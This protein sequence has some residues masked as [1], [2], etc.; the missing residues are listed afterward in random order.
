M[1]PT[2]YKKV[3]FAVKTDIAKNSPVVKNIKNQ[4]ISGNKDLEKLNKFFSTNSSKVEIEARMGSF[5]GNYFQSGVPFQVFNRIKTVLLGMSTK[6]GGNFEILN[7][8][9]KVYSTEDYLKIINLNTNQPP[10]Y[11]SKQKTGKIDVY[12]WNY[13]ISQAVE[14]NLN[15]A[16][17][18]EKFNDTAFRIKER[19]SFTDRQDGYFFGVSIDMTKVETSKEVDIKGKNG[20]TTKQIKSFTSYE[21]EMERNSNLTLEDFM[22]KFEFLYFI[23]QGY[24]KLFLDNIS[25]YYNIFN[26]NKN[27]LM[28][29][30]VKKQIIYE[31]NQL[32]I[33]QDLNDTFIPQIKQKDD[34]KLI[35][36]RNEPKNIKIKDMLSLEKY[37]TTSKLD[38]IRTFAFFQKN[39]VYFVNPPYDIIRITKYTNLTYQD[40]IIDGEF[41]TN[42]EDK[43]N[44]FYM[45]DI[46]RLY[47]KSVENKQ[48]HTRYELLK[49]ASEETQLFINPINFQL[50]TFYF[51]SNFYENIRDTLLDNNLFEL[52]EI[53]TDG[54]IIQPINKPYLNRQTFKWKPIEQLT[55]DF[56]VVSVI[57]E[58]EEY[59]LTTFDKFSNKLTSFRGTSDNPFFKTTFISDGIFE[60]EKINNRIVEFK[61]DYDHEVFVPM[62]YRDDRPIPNRSDVATSVWNDIMNPIYKST[63]EG[64]DLVVMR[65]YHNLIKQHL[66]TQYV[67]Q[68]STMLDIG[69]GRG[70]DLLKWKKLN[71]K[72][73]VVEPNEEVIVEFKRRQENLKTDAKIIMA[74]AQDTKIIT[75]QLKGEKVDVI[76]AFFSLTFFP[77]N[78]EMFQGLIDTIDQTLKNEG[79]LIGIVLDGH[80]VMKLL[81]TLKTYENDAFSIRKANTWK[82]SAFGNKLLVNIN[83]PS[84]M[85]KEVHEYLFFFDE[86]KNRLRNIGINLYLQPTIEGNNDK[87]SLKSK[88]DESFIDK[89]TEFLPHDAQIFSGLNRCFVFQR[90]KLKLSPPLTKLLKGDEPIDLKFGYDLYQEASINDNSSLF[91]AIVQTFSEDYRHKTINEKKL[92]IEKIRKK[93]AFNMSTHDFDS[94]GGGILANKLTKSYKIY[95]KNEKTA[96]TLS[97][98][99]MIN[100]LNNPNEWIGDNLEIVQLLSDKLGLD[101]YLV[102]NKS[103]NVYL[104]DAENLISKNYKCKLLYKNRPSVIILNIDNLRFNVIKQNNKYLFPPQSSI[105]KGIRKQLCTATNITDQ[106]QDEI[107]V[108]Y[109][110]YNKWTKAIVNNSDVL[111]LEPLYKNQKKI[112]VM[113]IDPSAPP[114]FRRVNVS[115]LIIKTKSQ[116][117]FETFKK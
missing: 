3:S 44:V 28:P 43:R 32:L 100:L 9:T 94:L 46:L 75:K 57:D 38:G 107:P 13:R 60:N 105:I 36:Y 117:E 47:S 82:K 8:N 99:K 68:G 18:G 80:K 30:D 23:Y 1:K 16:P 51:H 53:K 71:L 79:M 15:K 92:F 87:L 39:A 78:E 106:S 29:V 113:P 20:K 85:V 97:I 48:F 26:K 111:L 114:Q 62:R 86:F 17:E 27:L 96:H 35:S 112:E 101:I 93:I 50:K 102:D 74:G 110:E 19:T 41:V 88:Y 12:K 24:N 61:W 6:K 98:N 109:L 81:S 49:K 84:S 2:K 63:I 55:I 7:T 104:P 77:K 14:Q 73:T 11:R 72:V 56:Q 90:T 5:D 83:D 103:K 10:F 22:N 95:T 33:N 116:S 69:S 37:A 21:I 89:N 76:A 45:F 42:I 34:E 108:E 67:A 52:N 40:T 4:L 65:K 58:E 115:D 64:D 54:I 25:D 59:N 70:G 31:F 66:L 91:H